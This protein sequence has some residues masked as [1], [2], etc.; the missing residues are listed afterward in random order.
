M[1]KYKA[2]ICFTVMDC[3]LSHNP[4]KKIWSQYIFNRITIILQERKL[5]VDLSWRLECKSFLH[6]M[7]YTV[8]PYFR[9]SVG[10]V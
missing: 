3:E 5:R 1:D 6:F 4:Q 7:Y 2:K 10:E 9:V 8:P